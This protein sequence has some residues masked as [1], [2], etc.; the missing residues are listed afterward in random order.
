MIQFTLNV[1]L[2]NFASTLFMKLNESEQHVLK[3]DDAKY[4]PHLTSNLIVLG[5]I[6]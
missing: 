6:D 3:N 4:D 2:L 1:T 5:Q